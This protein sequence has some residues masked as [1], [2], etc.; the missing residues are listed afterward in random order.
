MVELGA[1]VTTDISVDS[2]V[3]E[4]RGNAVF[5][6]NIEGSLEAYI[7]I[8]QDLLSALGETLNKEASGHGH[9]FDR[10]RAVRAADEA[11]VT[12]AE[13]GVERI[14]LDAGFAGVRVVRQKT[15]CSAGT[16]VDG[17]E[18]DLGLERCRD[19]VSEVEA[20]KTE[21]RD[22]AGDLLGEREDNAESRGNLD[23]SFGSDRAYLVIADLGAGNSADVV[24]VALG[25]EASA[26]DGSREG[27]DDKGQ[28]LVVVSHVTVGADSE[29]LGKN[30]G[31]VGVRVIVIILGVGI[32]NLNA[33]QLNID[34]KSDL[35]GI[36]LVE[37]NIEDLRVENS[38]LQISVIGRARVLNNEK[39]LS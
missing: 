14:V 11:L 10:G 15:D 34:I 33:G 27:V 7:H 4:S 37:G 25:A 26:V 19:K 13:I 29:F 23:H 38:L 28:E 12:F 8:E 18:R 1:Q 22:Q 31:K 20:G 17:V 36:A 32:R 5:A 21:L 30:S 9:L 2:V 16:A 6:T 24:A 39:T 35:A 3:G